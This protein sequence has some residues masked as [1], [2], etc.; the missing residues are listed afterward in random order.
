MAERASSEGSKKNLR[1]KPVSGQGIPTRSTRN[2]ARSRRNTRPRTA[3]SESQ[4]QKDHLLV[5]LELDRTRLQLEI[6]SLKNAQQELQGMHERLFNQLPIGFVTI[7][8]SGVIKVWNAGAQELLDPN[9][10]GLENTPLTFFVIREDVEI[11]LEHLVNCRRAE[12][13]Q[14]VSE[15]RLRSG[16]GEIPVQ[17]VSLPF[18]TE[19]VKYYQ[20]ALINLTE[21][22]KHEGALEAAKEFS[23]AIIQTIHEPLVVLDTHFRVM[24]M[25]GEFAKMFR[26]PGRLAKGWSFEAIINLPWKERELR[27]RFQQALTKGIPLIDFEFEARSPAG[28]RRVFRCNARRLEQKEYSPTLLLV[29]LE[30]VTTR[31]EAADKLSAFTA[32]LQQLNDE[33]ESRVSERTRALSQSNRQLETF[34]YTIA[35]DL[36]GP[37]RAM[38]GFSMALTDDYA[39]TLGDRGKD[40]LKR[41]VS[42]SERMD[43]M[44]RALLEYGRFTT[45]E[46]TNETVDADDV[47]DGVIGDLTPEIEKTQ[48]QIERK[49][50][51]PKISGHKAVLQAAFANL[52]GNALKFV[53]PKVS[54]KVTIWSEENSD[55]T[56][57]WVAD[58][59][60]GIPPQYHKQIFEV[61]QRL[62]PQV[63]YPGTGIGLA[64]VSKAIERIGGAVGVESQP[65]HGSRFWISLRKP[66]VSDQ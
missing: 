12:Q 66:V 48:A 46:L 15:V 20:T 62:H 22:K 5:E 36:R 51:L 26:C 61:F 18:T 31:K 49:S 21:R 25:N 34:C 53:S 1:R 59:G 60:I 47:L 3:S 17:I 35:H 58:N 65:G 30:D 4:P 43:E 41:I 64:I 63:D 8:N 55:H 11:M 52:V 56:R 16:N 2:Q 10:R 28:V 39:P 7:N 33:L 32:K 9:R 38:A 40:F 14:V 50:R 24:H 13:G 27:S 6:E 57:I 23:D 44:I 42:A 29:A 54:P 19:N 45:A 37:L